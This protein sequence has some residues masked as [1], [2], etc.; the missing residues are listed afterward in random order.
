MKVGSLFSSGIV[1]LTIALTVTTGPS[2]AEGATSGHTSA[3]TGNSSV[4]SSPNRDGAVVL[5]GFPCLVPVPGAPPA[6]TFR[7]HTVT[8][9]SGNAA[10]SCHATTQTGLSRA[11]VVQ[12]APCATFSGAGTDSHLVL[13]PSGRVNFWCHHHR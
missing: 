10:V 4:V 6:I 2:T 5:K 8:T 7:S 9:P 3:V 13:T 1:G 12:D 11:V